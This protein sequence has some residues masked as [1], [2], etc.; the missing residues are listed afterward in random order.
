MRVPADSN[1][2]GIPDWIMTRD[3]QVPAHSESGTLYFDLDRNSA[4]QAGDAVLP[5]AVLTFTDKEFPYQRTVTSRPDGSFTVASLPPGTYTL[6]VQANGRTV[7]VADGTIGTA[8]VTGNVAVPY[9]GVNGI[10]TSSLGG[11]V[12]GATIEAVDET[13]GTTLRFTAGSDGSY[14]LRPLMAGNYTLTATSGD[15]ASNPARMRASNVDFWLNLTLR[16]SGTVTGTTTVFGAARPFA[17]LDFQSAADPS[18][19]R[20][21]TSDASARYAIRIPAGEWFVSGRSYDGTTLYATLGRV[22]VAA[23]ATTAFDG[24]FI[25]GARVSGT[26]SDPNPTVRNPQASVAFVSGAGQR[27]LTT[28]A[29]GGYLA[30]LPAGTYD[31]EAFNAAAASFSSLTLLGSQTVDI[32]L[33]NASEAVRGTVYRDVNGNGV[34]DPGEAVAAAHI[35]LTD[36]TGAHISLTAN[37]T[38]GFFVPLFGNRTYA[39]SVSALG[40]ETRTIPTSSPASLRALFPIALVPTPVDVH[41]SVL[42]NGAPLLNRPVT[43]RAAAIG[44]GAVSQTTLTDSNGGYGLQLAPGTYDL[45]VDENVSTTR[46]SRYQNAGSDSIDATVAEAALSHDIAIVTRVRVAGNVTLSGVPQSASLSFDGPEHRAAE[47]TTAGFEVYLVPGSYAVSGTKQIVPDQYAFI[48]T[49]TAPATG[50][51][52]ALVKATR[53]AGHALFN[54]AGVAGPMPVSFARAE[55]GRVNVSIDSSGA[56]TAY[57]VPGNYTIT[58]T[59][60]NSAAESGVTRF[61]A[62]AFTGSLTVAPGETEIAFDL[63]VSRRLDNTTVSGIVSFA[64][65]GIDAT[66]TFTARGGGAITASA[67]SGSDGSY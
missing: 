45:L 10:A 63:V 14:A 29:T 64:G 50:L 59:G 54:G 53:V 57:L 35:A 60:T 66:V 48:S 41:G 49:A 11:P 26:V 15:L 7:R 37:A 5:G 47:A 38:G 25:Q 28:S 4:F 31:L 8:D 55:G 24:R 16:P 9:A 22:L 40:F 46:D 44:E 61:Y 6:K 13:N 58:L 18:M 32:R 27:W 67:S 42:L 12:A 30:F 19:V 3:F 2:D 56:Y 62:Y 65:F 43:V 52:Y 1:G 17:S 34:F 51:T 23:G 36:N 39:G 21:A 20:T 33:V